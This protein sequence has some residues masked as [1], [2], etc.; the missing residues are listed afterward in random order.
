MF[1]CQLLAT[2]QNRATQYPVVTLTGPRQSGKT[3]LC[4]TA[5]PETPYR[6]LE[7]PDIRNF[8]QHDPAG[9]LVKFPDGAILDKAQRV[10]ELLS[11]TW[12]VPMNTKPLANS[13]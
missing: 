1:A 2:L 9:F 12:Y 4:R 13:Y 7:R 8:A 10:P 11:W 5:F 3:T 6:N